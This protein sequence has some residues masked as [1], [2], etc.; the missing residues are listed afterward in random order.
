MD[1]WRREADTFLTVPASELAITDWRRFLFQYNAYEVATALKSHI[2]AHLLRVTSFNR[3]VFLDIDVAVYSSLLPIVDRL[4]HADIVLTPQMAM[5]RSFVSLDQWEA[6]VLD[7][8]TFNSGFVGIRRSEAAQQM[9][10]WWQ[11]RVAKHCKA[12]INTL[13]QGWL[14]PVPALFD[15]VYIERGAQFNLT[16]QNLHM[17]KFSRDFHGEP[18][19]DGKPLSFFHFVAIDPLQTTKL[20]KASRQP[21]SEEP[22]LI[23]ELYAEYLN[24]LRFNGLTEFL[25]MGYQYARL[26]DGTLI[27]EDWRELIRTDHPA[28]RGAEDPFAIPAREF[29]RVAAGLRWKRQFQR[30]LRGMGL[31]SS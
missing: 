5:P 15:G 28:F 27:T 1:G 10:A 20:S 11:T 24:Q 25:S 6:D 13:D 2:L 16:P 22:I 26:S 3:I 17:R 23:Q 14:D 19:I 21:I 9:L 29:G 7:T 30:V 18:L 8:G 4:N 31:S 12:N